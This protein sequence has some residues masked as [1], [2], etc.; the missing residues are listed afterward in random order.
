MSREPNL[1]RSPDYYSAR[2]IEERRLAMAST[3]PK[4]RAIHLQ[5]ANRYDVLA[6]GDDAQPRQVIGGEQRT[7]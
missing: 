1:N 2:A 3:D 7:A 5:M 6:A 4:V